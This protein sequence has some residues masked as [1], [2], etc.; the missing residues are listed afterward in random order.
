MASRSFPLLLGLSLIGSTLSAEVRT[1]TSK[2]GLKIEAEL[3]SVGESSIKIRRTDTKV[4]FDLPIAR[5]SAQDQE[6][7]KNRRKDNQ[8][9]AAEGDDKAAAAKN[10]QE[11]TDP[12]GMVRQP[13]R[14]GEKRP[15]KYPNWNDEWPERVQIDGAPEVSVAE[16]DPDKN[17][18]VYHSPNYAFICD[19]P[20]KGSVI[21]EFSKMFEATFEVMKALPLSHDLARYPGERKRFPIL[22]FGSKREYF[23]HGGTPNSAGFFRPSTGKVYI[24]LTSLG[25]KKVGSGYQKEFGKE[26]QTLA[27]ELVHQVYD[28]IYNVNGALGWYSEGLAE[29]V[30]VSPYSSTGKFTFKGNLRDIAKSF[31]EFDY[32]A[33]IG[34]GLG[35]EQEI[36]NLKSFFLQSYRSFTNNSRYNYAMGMLVTTYFIHM[37]GDGD[38]KNLTAFLKALREGKHGEDAIKVLLAGRTYQELAEDIATGWRKFGLRLDRGRQPRG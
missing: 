32:D 3:L 9:G 37:D 27:H 2:K 1:W 4:E 25:V 22:L 20:L 35:K 10:G 28:E 30:S 6:W 14:P 26:N 18:Y 34:S 23:R 15:A 21:K 29:Y 19:V 38:R 13:V 7:L 8:A 36:A 5:L 11:E 24:P 16:E 33:Q 12:D 31:S 17:R